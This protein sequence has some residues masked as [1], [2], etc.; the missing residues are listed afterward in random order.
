MTLGNMRQ[1]GSG[2]CSSPAR[3][4]ASTWRSMPTRG[5]IGCLRSDRVCGAR[6]AASLAVRPFRIGKSAPIVCLAEG[7]TWQGA[8]TRAPRVRDRPRGAVLRGCGWRRRRGLRPS[9]T[10]GIPH[11]LGR[12]RRKGLIPVPA[13]LY[14]RPIRSQMAAPALQAS[15][16][17]GV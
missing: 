17:R 2:G 4:A 15:T 6:S 13:G 9:G 8:P 11:P 14:A 12:N 10:G 16:A 1:N 7:G 3:P 5:L